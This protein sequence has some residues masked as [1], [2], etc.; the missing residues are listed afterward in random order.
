MRMGGGKCRR[1]CWPVHVLW[2]AAVCSDAWH[3]RTHPGDRCP[4]SLAPSHFL[5]AAAARSASRPRQVS[6]D[7]LAFDGRSD[8]EVVALLALLGA[9]RTSGLP[10]APCPG[11]ARV[12][13]AAG[14][15][16]SNPVCAD[17]RA[18]D[19]SLLYAGTGSCVQL[20][21]AR[22]RLPLGL[23]VSAGAPVEALRR[24]TVHMS[25]SLPVGWRSQGEKH[26]GHLRLCAAL[27]G[28]G[29][30]LC[31]RACRGRPCSRRACAL[32]WTWRAR[33]PC[34]CRPRWPRLAPPSETL[35][36]QT[37]AR[38]CTWTKL[39]WVPWHAAPRWGRN[40]ASLLCTSLTPAQWQ[41]ALA[42]GVLHQGGC[43]PPFGRSMRDQ[44]TGQQLIADLAGCCS[45]HT[46]CAMLKANCSS[47]GPAPQAA[48]CHRAGPGQGAPCGVQGPLEAV[49]ADHAA[50]TAAQLAAL[51]A[52]QQRL[53]GRLQE[54]GAFRMD[55]SLRTL[56]ACC[57]CT[58][59][60]LG[61]S[62]RLASRD[63]L[64]CRLQPLA[65][66]LS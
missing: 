53:E 26:C 34:P 15:L 54:T 18:A 37:P 36:Q 7:V 55:V 58:S 62:W 61:C 24:A 66:L 60:Q 42:Q 6:V 30:D 14:T 4:C 22:V 1:A 40:P 48:G 56:H 31:Q 27:L 41:P 23:C 8:L 12:S 46:G 13:C 21:Q 44:Y 57:C 50:G 10:G 33:R 39:P 47:S 43:R 25:V 35:P 3:S 64:C 5:S 2:H 16:A 28:A 63:Y 38:S 49:L 20:L 65:Q 32:R 45:Q 29:A 59:V 11:V 52:L 17:E 19:L 9:F 51:A